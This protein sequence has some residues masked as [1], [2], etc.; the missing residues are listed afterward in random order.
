MQPVWQRSGWNVRSRLLA[1]GSP[2]D[3]DEDDDQND[4]NEHDDN[5]HNYYDDNN[6][7]DNE[8]LSWSW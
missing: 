3:D 5:D 4:D 7:D 8:D 2:G 6:D 1:Q